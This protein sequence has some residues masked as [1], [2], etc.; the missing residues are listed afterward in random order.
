M[1]TILPTSLAS[2]VYG[3]LLVAPV[4]TQ[5]RELDKWRKPWT[6][7]DPVTP[8]TINSK[9]STNLAVSG[10]ATI[11]DV[12]PD[13]LPNSVSVVEM[14]ALLMAKGENF[15]LSLCPSTTYQLETTLILT[16]AGQEVSTLGYPTDD[17]RAMLV[18]AGSKNLETGMS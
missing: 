9:L 1:P 13:C 10:Y 17:T 16:A 2:F 11:P 18:V 14:N 5:A 8:S 15:V 3:L 4:I 6:P 7:P 12:L